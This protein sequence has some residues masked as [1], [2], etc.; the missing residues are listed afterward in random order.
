MSSV[1]PAPGRIT[2]HVLDTA[3]GR[4]G[5]S[6]SLTLH[7]LENGG[8]ELLGRFLTNADGRCDRPLLEGAAMRPGLY[9]ITFHV[10][11][12]R[13]AEETFFDDIP[14]RFRVSDPH[15]HHHV[16]LILAPFGYTTYRG[17]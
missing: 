5:A 10:A 9:E 15:A 1:V 12:W 11:E 6:M 2:T 3:A 7:R 8:R 4:P 17:S 16:P 14:I 13:A